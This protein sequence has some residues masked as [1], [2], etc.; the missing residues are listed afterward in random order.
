MQGCGGAHFPHGWSLNRSSSGTGAAVLW[1]TRAVGST[2]GCTWLGGGLQPSHLTA[3]S[4]KP[5][6]SRAK[7]MPGVLLLQAEG[8]MP[9]ARGLAGTM[10]GM[11]WVEGDKE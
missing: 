8:T 2:D 9:R 3:W 11:S 5:P 10:P 4:T 1:V 7:A 6:G